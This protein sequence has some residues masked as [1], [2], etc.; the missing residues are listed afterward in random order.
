MARLAKGL[1]WSVVLL[2]LLLVG[3]DCGKER[4]AQAGGTPAVMPTAT[5]PGVAQ[6]PSP[7]VS[8][9]VSP[10][11]PPAA[12][13]QLNA[14]FWEQKAPEYRA[15]ARTLYG[16]ARLRLDQAL[17]NPGW[18]ALV[19]QNDNRITTLPP[20]P[21]IILDIDETVLDNSPLF[22]RQ[23]KDP[24]LEMGQ[25]W[26]DWTAEGKAEA[27]AGAAD[28]VRYAVRRG[29]AVFFVSNRACDQDEATRR[30]LSEAGF[31]EEGVYLISR[32]TGY[33]DPDQVIACPAMESLVKRLLNIDQ[34]RW[35]L[36]KFQRRAAIGS[37]Y[38]VLLQFGD[39]QGDFYSTLP[40]AND[41][42][43]ERKRLLLGHLT[44]Q[45][46]DRIDRDHAGYYADRWMALPNAAY[47]NWQSSYLGYRSL[48]VGQQVADELK[49]LKTD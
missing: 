6:S 46:R 2:P 16:N 42:P 11:P 22:A 49:M 25:A 20:A 7:E 10:T 29:V 5:P 19:S 32:N 48:S 31:P 24:T 23:A 36:A 47:G 38:R 45:E 8:P 17:A 35:Y 18:S 44:P 30:N 14:V 39:S 40:G 41:S 1:G 4:A 37:R 33:A 43:E 34:P 27:V 13:P 26:R 15:A 12:V 9:S 3:C 28:F 21:A